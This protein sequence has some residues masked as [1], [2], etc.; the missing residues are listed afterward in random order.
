MTQC[1]VVQ[2]LTSR[3]WPSALWSSAL[4]LNHED[5]LTNSW[6]RPWMCVW[7]VW[8]Y[9]MFYDHFSAH[10]LLVNWVDEDDDEDEV[11]LKESQK[12][13]DTSKRKTRRLCVLANTKLYHRN[14]LLWISMKFWI[15]VSTTLGFFSKDP[16]IYPNTRIKLTKIKIRSS[17]GQ[18]KHCSES[19]I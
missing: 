11:G 2:C 18:F 19:L 4:P 12:T 1:A 7:G 13:L 15:L 5:R 8:F 17:L 3:P 10:S 6:G 16:P 9:W 14:L